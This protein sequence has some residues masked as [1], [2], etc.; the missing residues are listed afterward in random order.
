MPGVEYEFLGHTARNLAV[1]L[2][3]RCSAFRAIIQTSYIH[4]ASFAV[5]SISGCKL[6][7]KPGCVLL[8][9][10]WLLPQKFE[11][12]GGVHGREYKYGPVRNMFLVLHTQLTS[13]LLTEFKR[14]LTRSSESSVQIPLTLLGYIPEMLFLFIILCPF[15]HRPLQK[16]LLSQNYVCN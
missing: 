1:P 9:E 10:M 8:C 12:H 7:H 11:Q 14:Q 15:S 5:H 2:P 16:R 4:F 3:P 6:H 13:H